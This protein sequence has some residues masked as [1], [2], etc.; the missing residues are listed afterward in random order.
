MAEKRILEQ[1]GSIWTKTGAAKMAQSVNTGIPVKPKTI[2]LGD[3]GGA[4][5]VPTPEQ[6]QLVNEVYRCDISR[7]DTYPGDDAHLILY[8]NVPA[9]VGSFVIREIGIL[10]EAGDLLT[11][12]SVPDVAKMQPNEWGVAIDLSIKYHLIISTEAVFEVV[13]DPAA[14]LASM[15]D[16]LEL[17]AR[18]QAQ[19]DTVPILERIGEDTIDTW[20]DMPIGSITV[21]GEGMTQD[22]VSR[23]LDDDPD[24]DPEWN[25]PAILKQFELSKE[26]VANILDS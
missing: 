3:G 15:Q 13:I 14:V 21:D 5:Y 23:I 11:V 7:R 12:A 6:S 26:E 18:L 4:G 10:D 9:D 22:E 1:A 16:V 20:D 19:I 2:V 25:E 8:G 17:E 24:N